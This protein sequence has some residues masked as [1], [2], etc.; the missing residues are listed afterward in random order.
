MASAKK[1]LVMSARYQVSDRPRE[2]NHHLPIYFLP[3]F[4]NPTFL[5]WKRENRFFLNEATFMRT[6]ILFW[7]PFH[8][9]CHDNNHKTDVPQGKELRNLLLGSDAHKKVKRVNQQQKLRRRRRRRGYWSARFPIWIF[10]ISSLPSSSSLFVICFPLLLF[11]PF[12]I[13]SSPL[14]CSF[15]SPPRHCTESRNMASL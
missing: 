5:F 10:R 12:H 15:D 11:L 2:W 13:R 6:S 8:S 7:C 1:N 4:S 3:S 14:T 9:H